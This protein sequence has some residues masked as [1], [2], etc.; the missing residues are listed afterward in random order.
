M[1]MGKVGHCESEQRLQA[2]V[3]ES[4]EEEEVQ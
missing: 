1:K 3:R 2:N 4:V